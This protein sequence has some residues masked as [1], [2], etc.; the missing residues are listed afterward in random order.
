MARPLNPTTGPMTATERQ[1]RWRTK[2]RLRKA[3]ELVAKLT[4]EL[5][6]ASPPARRGDQHQR[7]R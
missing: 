1:R 4:A 7:R 5:A 2:V 3:V 6:S